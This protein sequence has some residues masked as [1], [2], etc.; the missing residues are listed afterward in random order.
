[1]LTLAAAVD[2]GDAVRLLIF[3]FSC[4]SAARL[5]RS[6]PERAVPPGTPHNVPLAAFLLA[7]GW[8]CIALVGHVLTS[9]VRPQALQPRQMTVTDFQYVCLESVLITSILFLAMQIPRLLTEPDVPPDG[10]PCPDPSAEGPIPTPPVEAPRVPACSRSVVPAGSRG[11]DFWLGI[12]VGLAAIL[13][14]VVAGVVLQ[15]F[16]QKQ[17]ELHPYLE[18]LRSRDAATIVTWVFLAAVIFAPMKEELI[19][20]VILHGRLADS[21]GT[22]GWIA[23]AVLFAA[24]HDLPDALLLLPL[25]LLLGDLY[26]RRRS[27]LAVVAAHATFN[28]ANVVMAISLPRERL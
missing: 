13:P 12:N 16:G 1:M 10:A 4:F 11:A 25:A 22:A 6:P 2:R 21:Y 14:T 7:A 23:T 17:H 5:L 26:E 28:A 19:F 9:H 24:V 15:L 20:R 27:Y 8:A 3:G 18:L